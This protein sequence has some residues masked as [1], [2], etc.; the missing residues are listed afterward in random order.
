MREKVAKL[1]SSLDTSR[2]LARRV[3]G[4]SSE[5]LA[6][7][8]V[9]YNGSARHTKQGFSDLVL[10]HGGT[11]CEIYGPSAEARP[12][13]APAHET[14]TCTTV[15]R[16]PLHRKEI[17]ASTSRLGRLGLGTLD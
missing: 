7:V 13:V 9:H 14:P 15:N 12:R 10:A 4:V 1:N 8:C 2:T 17:D 11:V 6:G 5:V 3:L 16:P